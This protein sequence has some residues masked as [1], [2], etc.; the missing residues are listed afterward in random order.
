M[1]FEH[2]T[3]VTIITGIDITDITVIDIIT[4][5]IERNFLVKRAAV[6]YRSRRPFMFPADH[7]MF[8]F[9]KQQNQRIVLDNEPSSTGR[10]KLF[11]EMSAPT[12]GGVGGW[13]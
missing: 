2:I 9:F 3:I 5:T 13:G 1:L 10:H 7:R 11:G 6:V 4:G 8:V 12:S